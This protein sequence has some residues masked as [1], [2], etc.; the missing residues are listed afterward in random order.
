MLLEK[1]RQMWKIITLGM[2]KN[3]TEK[4][5]VTFSMMQIASTLRKILKRSSGSSLIDGYILM[6]DC[7]LN[8]SL[9]KN[10]YN[11]TIILAYN[12]K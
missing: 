9:L 11:V 12:D 7:Q 4:E 3:I 5:K 2:R 6:V 8:I 10:Q 1:Q